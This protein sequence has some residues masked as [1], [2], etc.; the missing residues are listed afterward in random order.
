[1]AAENRRKGRLAARAQ[2]GAAHSP[3]MAETLAPMGAPRRA[4]PAIM[5]EP[6][7]RPVLPRQA[8]AVQ[9]RERAAVDG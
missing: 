8:P 3:A 7:L 2:A 1:M 5:V 6:A 9:R 4:A